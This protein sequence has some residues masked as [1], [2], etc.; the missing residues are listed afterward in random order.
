MDFDARQGYFLP[1]WR[2]PNAIYHVIFRQAD[3]LPD[4]VL[5]QLR[6][7]N[8]EVDLPEKIATYLD[9]GHGSC[10]CLDPRCA[11]IVEGALKF[12]DGAR[13][14][15]VA[16]AVMPNHTHAVLRPLAGIDLSKITHSWKSYTSNEINR[17]LA[18][19]G[20]LWHKESFDRIIRDQH[21]FEETI[22]YVLDNP[23]VAG[24]GGWRWC[25]A[26]SPT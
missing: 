11:D 6:E 23:K 2:A 4:H 12:F 18:M 21:E 24:L 25:G 15:L 1:H 14:D 5:L 8:E 16:W 26:K 13:Y 20:T 7:Q 9:A 3:S 17:T 10:V 19:S 22:R